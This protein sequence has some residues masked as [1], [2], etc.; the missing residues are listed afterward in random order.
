MKNL[1]LFMLLMLLISCGNDNKLEQAIAQINTDISVERFDLLFGKATNNDLPELKRAYPFMFSEKFPDSFWIAKIRD[2]I[3][4]ELVK[5]VAKVFPNLDE[6]E[7][8]IESLFNHLKYYF[9]EFNTPRVITTTSMV[10]YRNRIIVTDTIA[11][12]ALDNYLGKDHFFYQEIQKYIRKNF[13]AKQIVVDL[14]SEYAGRYIYQPQRKTLLDEMVYFGKQLYF[15][16]IMLPNVSEAER[17]GYSESELEWARANEHYV[18]RYFVE[19]ELL[20][21]AD[22]KLPSR[23][24]NPAPFS[25]FYLEEIDTDSPGRLGQYI[26]WQIVR[27]YMKNNEVSVK[28]MLQMKPE[29]I[30]NNSKFKPLK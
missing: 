26:G 27:A 9:P 25:K 4:Q 14:A 15:K 29:D 10:D 30:F 1:M 2:T 21:S 8:D 28:D 6:E 17:I 3:Q 20:Y 22:T 11:I 24:I 23:F 13:E 18:W 16:D 7:M 5:E 12:I 19:R